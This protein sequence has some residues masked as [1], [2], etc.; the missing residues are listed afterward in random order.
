MADVFISYSRSDGDFV[1]ELAAALVERGKEPWLDVE[2]IEGGEEFPTVIRRA[3]EETDGL[4]FVISEAAVASPYCRQEID[5]SLQLGKRV[6]PVLHRRVADAALPAGVRDRHWVLAVDGL[7]SEAANRIAHALDAEPEHTRQHTRLLVRALDWDAEGRR[8]EALPR[9]D[10]LARAEAWLTHAPGREPAPTTLHTEWVAAGRAGAARRQRRLVVGAVLFGIV[11]LGLLAFALA[12]RREAVDA[13]SIS[14]S[15]ALAVEA[16]NQVARDPQRALLLARAA[17]R[18]AP[19]PE[20]QLAASEALDVNTV[21]SQLPSFGLQRC[22]DANYMY[23]LDHGR[24][25]VDNACDGDVVFADIPARRVTRR[26]HVGRTST[27]MTLSGDQQ[28]LTVATGRDLVDVDVKSGRTRHLYRSPWPIEWTAYAP[29][30]RRLAIGDADKIAIVDLKRRRQRVVARGD[31]SA[32]RIYGMLWVSRDELLVASSGLTRGRGNLLPALTVLNVVSGARSTVRLAKPP[33]LAAVGFLNVAADFRTWYITGAEINA[34]NSGQVA[35][36]WAIDARTRKVKW[37]NRGPVGAQANPVVPSPD[38]KLVSVGYTQGAVDVLDAR[39]GHL[40]V[41]DGG[42]ASIVA[43]W[44]GFPPG[45]RT[46]VTLSLDGVIRTWAARGSEQIRFQAPPAPAL[47]FTPDGRALVLVGR[48]GEVRDRRGEAVIRRFAGFPAD[49]VFN[50]CNSACFATSPSLD[51]LTYVDT[52]TSPPRVVELEGR[53]GRRVGAAPVRRLDTQGVAPDGH[54][55]TAYVDGDRLRAEVIDPR[56]G[57]ARA[58]PTAESSDGCFA[59]TPSFTAD[60]RLMA[61]VDGCLDLAVWDLRTARLR[62][63]IVLPER[64]TGS[65]ARLSPDGRFVLA[66]VE[67]GGLLRI[68]LATGRIVERLGTKSPAKVIAISPDGRFYAVGHQDGTIEQYD[69]R[70]LR[71]V[72]THILDSA[73]QALAFSPDGRALAVEDIGYDVRVW[74]TCDVCQDPKR[75]AALAARQ[76]VRELSPGERATFDVG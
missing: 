70:S 12:S 40:V 58:L 3:I 43:G 37:V 55:G 44:M 41:R 7:T 48:H 59:A 28:T 65:G 22:I 76:S 11:T 13:Q 6:V 71:V 36:T 49:T 69:A 14:R 56:T 64:A 67:G 74:D 21:R 38:G 54:V 57:R 16:S 4:V 27:D 53:S 18:A 5:Y 33:H 31:A 2:G 9:G 8:H 10:E 23:L 30:G 25:A 73:V 20:A 47:A 68:G 61:V 45:D 26:I 24:T 19:T 17:L 50:F 66:T 1:R 35:T 60:S 63:T 29:P 32:N 39:D 75:L 15:R 42:S 46:L 51:W 52:S 34:G 72:R 62:R